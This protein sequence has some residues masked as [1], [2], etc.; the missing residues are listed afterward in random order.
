MRPIK[1]KFSRTV[2]TSHWVYLLIIDRAL[3]KIYGFLKVVRVGV[4]CLDNKLDPHF[5]PFYDS[6]PMKSSF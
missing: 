4:E 1:H 3:Q 2:L 5:T 6:F